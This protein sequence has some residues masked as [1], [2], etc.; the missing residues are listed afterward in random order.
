MIMQCFLYDLYINLIFISKCVW[1][2]KLFTRQGRVMVYFDIKPQAGPILTFHEYTYTDTMWRHIN[3][4][5][6]NVWQTVPNKRLN[7]CQYV[8]ISHT[9]VS[10]FDRK[11]KYEALLVC[12]TRILTLI[13]TIFVIQGRS[14]NGPLL[15]KTSCFYC[16]A[17]L[18]DNCGERFDAFLLKIS[19]MTLCLTTP[20]FR[21]YPSKVMAVTSYLIHDYHATVNFN[22]NSQK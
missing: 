14:Q 1:L 21:Q 16:S 19:F 10:S 4:L 17:G 7:H 9:C 2:H 3:I 6:D 8:V 5:S 20:H 13:Q 18:V 22:W 12:E 11:L 15:V